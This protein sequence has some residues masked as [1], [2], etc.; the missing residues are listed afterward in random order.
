MINYKNK[1]VAFVMLQ[2]GFAGVSSFVFDTV[3]WAKNNGIEADI[4]VYKHQNGIFNLKV[5]QFDAEFTTFEDSEIEWLMEKLKDYD[6]IVLNDTFEAKKPGKAQKYF[7]EKW[8]TLEPL[9]IYIEH[10]SQYS[11]FSGCAFWYNVIAYSDKIFS[12]SDN[13]LIY[14]AIMKIPSKKDRWRKA[15]LFIDTEKYK[16]LQENKD[17]E[18]KIIYLGRFAA[19]KDIVRILDMSE[20]LKEN[21]IA[22][23]IRGLD[24]SLASYHNVLKRPEAIDRCEIEEVKNEEHGYVNVYGRVNREEGLHIRS[25]CLFSAN[26]FGFKKNEKKLA[27]EQY[28][29]I[30]GRLEFTQLETI[31][32]GCI[33]VFDIDHGKASTLS[34]GRKLIDIEN[35]AI[36]SDRQDLKATV[37]KMK[38]VSENKELQEK[39]RQTSFEILKNEFDTNI[40]LND[41][42]KDIFD[43]TKDTY[44]VSVED[45]V[46]NL[47]GEKGLAIY[48][49]AYDNNMS[50][51]VSPK[52]LLERG[53]V[54]TYKDKEK[55]VY[56]LK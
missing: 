36:W 48:K 38:E 24:R 20:D 50:L 49:E 41:F 42:F 43:T 23:E 51:I 29:L 56:S 55:I 13:C 28:D 47:Y 32:C 3:E 16:G 10:A 7:V 26:F 53:Q 14:D 22:G 33:P 17:R 45:I 19:A 5:K 46:E 12:F 31:A 4:F 37:K 2:F 40:V 54:I 21:N 8:K 34:D 1:K 52:Q 25:N 27:R 30:G 15:K 39:I 35:F 18:N 6:A 44:E 11:Y 9:K